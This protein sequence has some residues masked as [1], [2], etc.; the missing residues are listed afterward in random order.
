[1]DFPKPSLQRALLLSLPGAALLSLPVGMWF[2]DFA[3]TK[4]KV[5]PTVLPMLPGLV[6]LL[7]FPTLATIAVV[8]SCLAIFRSSSAF[9]RSLLRVGLIL[10]NL[11]GI[12]AGALL[13]AVWLCGGSLD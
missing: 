4:L 10:F 7:V 1:M 12:F 9:D 13:T 6:R 2:W 5:V 3:T 11:L 8:T